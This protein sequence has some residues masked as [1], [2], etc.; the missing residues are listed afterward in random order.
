MGLGNLLSNIGNGYKNAKSPSAEGL[1]L[2]SKAI[3]DAKNKATGSNLSEKQQ[4]GLKVYNQM[5]AK[6]ITPKEYLKL[7]AAERTQYESLIG[8]NQDAKGSSGQMVG[9]LS[10]TFS[11]SREAQED[12]QDSGDRAGGILSALAGSFA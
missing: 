6:K 7:P 5:N 8:S 10:D 12:K 11:C 4:Q 3:T 2:Q 9:A 1:N